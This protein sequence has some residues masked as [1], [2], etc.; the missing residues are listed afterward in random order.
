MNR[1][2]LTDIIAVTRVGTANT[3]FEIKAEVGPLLV[4]FAAY[5]PDNDEP[6]NQAKW[7]WWVGRWWHIDPDD[8]K[9]QVLN[10]LFKAAL[11]Y[12]EHELRE[13]FNYLGHRP[14]HPHH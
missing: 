12:Q 3:Q 8:T 2:E 5:G 9:A 11:T 10:T 13:R 4:R 6:A 14:F 7:Q 1:Q